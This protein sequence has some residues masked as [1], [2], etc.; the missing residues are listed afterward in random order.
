[1]NKNIVEKVVKK[2]VLNALEVVTS[3]HFFCGLLSLYTP[4]PR[5]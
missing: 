1:M 5:F 3:Y 2:V 4:L